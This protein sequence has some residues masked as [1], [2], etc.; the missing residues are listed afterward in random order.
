M[1]KLGLVVMILAVLVSS[2]LAQPVMKWDKQIDSPQWGSVYLHGL[3][4]TSDG[5]FIAVGRT[6]TL[7]YIIK[8]DA[9]G[10]LEWEHRVGQDGV[11]NC[12]FNDVIETVPGV[13]YAAGYVHPV[14]NWDSEIQ[15]VKIE[16]GTITATQ[17]YS[18][19]IDQAAFCLIEDDAGDLWVGGNATLAGN[20]SIAHLLRVDSGDLQQLQQFGFPSAERI[21]DIIIQDGLF[22]VVGHVRELD[23]AYIQGWVA[24]INVGGFIMWQ[25]S[26]GTVNQIDDLRG[27]ALSEDG[28]AVQCVGY[29]NS[30]ETDALVARVATDGS[31]VVWSQQLDFESYYDVLWD[32]ELTDDGSDEYLALGQGLHQP[33]DEVGH[34]VL[35]MDASGQTIWSL[36][37]GSDEA[38]SNFTMTVLNGEELAFCGY[39]SD[40]EGYIKRI[41]Y[42]D[43]FDVTLTPNNSPVVIGPNG[44]YINMHGSISNLGSDY[45]AMDV[46]V[47]VENLVVQSVTTQTFSD[48]P[49][50]GG[51]TR[52]ANLSQGIPPWAPSGDY[53]MHLKI[54]HLPNE[55]LGEASFPFTKTGPLPNGGMGAFANPDA[56]PV[57]GSFEDAAAASAADADEKIAQPSE[58]MLG[59]AYPNP[60]NPATNF[61]V[62]LPE[63]A[64]LQ[65]T[66][67]DIT[68]RLVTTLANGSVS[69]GAHTF[70]F[71]GSGLASGVYFVRAASGTQSATQK[72]LLI[73]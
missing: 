19:Y 38:E 27:L 36:S 14:G 65:V 1:K 24:K 44:G 57:T 5:G 56:W 73:K 13:F 68:A 21:D 15:L 64:N 3:T 50:N 47:V 26:V 71:D 4:A 17:R 32:I 18:N 52:Q 30:G 72:L 31:G 29:S 10:N 66:V 45:L 34:R 6:G 9:V 12:W 67:H 59:A 58:F 55:V 39:D 46:W 51:Q 54:G 41:G 40:Y 23:P 70:T 62:Q 61:S 7:G 22:I 49:F 11:D 60:F 35:R 42:I 20:D 63:S 43:G 2:V 28:S 48:V 25:T 33:T 8:T 16:S 37:M 53:L 69:A